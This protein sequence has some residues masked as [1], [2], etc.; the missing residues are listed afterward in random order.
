MKFSLLLFMTFVG[1]LTGDDNVIAFRCC[2]SKFEFL[3][4]VWNE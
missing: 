1:F 4:F 3:Y 2:K